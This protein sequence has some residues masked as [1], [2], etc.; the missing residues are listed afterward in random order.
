MTGAGRMAFLEERFSRMGPLWGKTSVDAAGRS[1]FS[2]MG[3]LWGKNVCRRRWKKRLLPNAS[4][5][6]KKRLSTPLEEAPAPECVPSGENACVAPF[7]RSAF[8]PYGSPLGKNVCR[9]RWKKRLLPNASPLGK[10]PVSH[11]LEEARSPLWVPSGERLLHVHWQIDHRLLA[12]HRR[13]RVDVQ[14][15]LTAGLA[16]VDRRGK[17]VDRRLAHDA[18]ADQL[19]TRVSILGED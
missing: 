11:P 2:R 9:R 10:M 13:A 19:A 8:S 15:V 5:L 12:G 17:A 18:A 14:R 4:P 6:G 16:Q 1:A 7:G 3:P